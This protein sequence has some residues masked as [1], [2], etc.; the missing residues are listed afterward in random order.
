M[1]HVWK[2]PKGYIPSPASVSEGSVEPQATAG[3]VCYNMLQT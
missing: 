3:Y 2:E 1:L